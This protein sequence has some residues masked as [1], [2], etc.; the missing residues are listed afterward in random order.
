LVY[1]RQKRRL[2]NLDDALDLNT[3]NSSAPDSAKK[4]AFPTDGWGTALAKSPLFTC[5]EMDRHIAN[6][7]K[8][9]Q[10]SEYHFLPTGIRKAKD[11]LADEYLHKI[12]THQDQRY[13]YYRTKCFHSSKSERNYIT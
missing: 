10:N 3:P 12:Q 13:F 6:S 1:T 4:E 5:V 7:G 11:S 8:K 9:H 2:L